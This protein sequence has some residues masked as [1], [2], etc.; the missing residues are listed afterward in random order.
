MSTGRHVR[1]IPL[2]LLALCIALALALPVA[3]G[4]DDG[5]DDR[6]EVRRA[7]SCTRSSEAELR[8]RAEDGEIELRFE[9]EGPA[10]RSP[11]TVVLLHER[12]IAYRGKLSR[13][14]S[15]RRLELRRVLQDWF[16]QDS[17]VVRATGPRAETCRV[18]AVI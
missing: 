9:I 6:R 10:T 16:G 18:S 11:W 15:S 12:R 8:L 13:R 5:D 3:A 17:I 14:S 2:L 7:A 1:R 4:A